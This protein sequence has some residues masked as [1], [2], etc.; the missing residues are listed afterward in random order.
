MELNFEQIKEIIPHRYPL[1]LIDRVVELDPGKSAVAYKSVTGNEEFF[2]GHFPGKAVMPGV[3]IIEALAQTGAVALLSCEQYK[4]KLAL[5]GGIKKARFKRQVVPG[6]RLELHCTLTAQRGPVG[7]G[8]AV[9]KVDGEI[10]AT[11]E[12]TFVLE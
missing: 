7:M 1:L 2:C 3:L 10:A 8:E 6:D 9:A 11:A 5:F 12:L 4:G